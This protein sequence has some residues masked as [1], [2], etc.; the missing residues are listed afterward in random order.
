MVFANEMT[1]LLSYSG[2]MYDCDMPF[3]SIAHLRF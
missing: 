1:S 2:M 3:W